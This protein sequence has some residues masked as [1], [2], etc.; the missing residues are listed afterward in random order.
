MDL[1]T[2]AVEL[3][4]AGNNDLFDYIKA[5]QPI[6]ADKLSD[7]MKPLIENRHN[8]AV[9]LM[10]SDYQRFLQDNVQ[11][12][13]IRKG[14]D[15]YTVSGHIDDEIVDC[16]SAVHNVDK[17]AMVKTYVTGLMQAMN[18]DKDIEI[19]ELEISN[20][21]FERPA[22]KLTDQ[23]YEVKPNAPVESKSD[24]LEPKAPVEDAVEA[25]VETSV[26][27]PV[28]EAPV[29]QVNEAPVEAPVDEV[30]EAPVEDRAVYE[31]NGFDP[32]D[33]PEEPE[34]QPEVEPD[35]EF[36]FQPSTL[37]ASP[38][39]NYNDEVDFEEADDD[40]FEEPQA[41]VTE[42][43]PET[44]DDTMTVEIKN[45]KAFKIAHDYLVN[46]LKEHGLDKKIP[47]LHV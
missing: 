46:G 47:G 32:N 20:T 37:G 16:I 29:E 1:K 13:I 11:L 27:A 8:E 44:S 34:V 15:D 21:P 28:D 3:K 12:N 22:V 14:D 9:E 33:Y 36:G 6:P 24:A 23:S 31:Q 2:Y 25:P 18:R 39:D 26:E 41:D 19:D 5:N 38:W 10:V 7:S 40:L 17:E 30:F 35:P 43:Q 42:S 45:A 4:L